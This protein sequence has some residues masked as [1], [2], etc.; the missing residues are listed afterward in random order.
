MPLLVVALAPQEADLLTLAELD[1]LSARRVVIFEQPDHPL[2][3]RLRSAGVALAPLDDEPAAGA[4]DLG[5]VCDPASPRLLELAR[6]G[7]EVRHG[8]GAAPDPLSAAYG[9][10]IARR[11]ARA[12][13]ELLTV[14][15]RLR[16]AEG[17]PW[18]R[19]QSHASL[20]IHLLEE[21]YEVLQA[22]DEGSLGPE[23]EEELGDLLL[24][25]VFHAQMAADDGRFDFEGVARA[26]TGKLLHRHPHVFGEV[27]VSG[28]A[29]VV[30]NWEAIK[31]AEKERPGPFEDIPVALPALLG[32]YKAQKRAAALG[33]NPSADEARAHLRAILDDPSASVGEALFWLVAFA[34]A[35]RT[36]PEAALREAVVRFKMQMDPGGQGGS[37]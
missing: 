17:C 4:D 19:E 6:A 10:A 15:A 22:I 35:R 2:A 9:A 5:L 12:A 16:G 24:Q 32:A 29:E 7:A 1:E 14:M 23:L 26:I 18:D 20:R 30:R 27:E 25:V 11:G 36:D 28:A 21:A 33:F 8:P 31:A 34:R 13:A 3:A 37:A